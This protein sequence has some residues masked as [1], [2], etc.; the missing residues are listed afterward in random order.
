MIQLVRLG[1]L[2]AIPFVT[3]TTAHTTVNAETIDII[4][5][6]NERTGLIQTLN[7]EDYDSLDEILTAVASVIENNNQEIQSSDDSSSSDDQQQED[8]SSAGG[9]SGSGGS[10]DSSSSSSNSD[11]EGGSN[12]LDT[13]SF[14]SNAPTQWKAQD[15]NVIPVNAE[16]QCNEDEVIKDNSCI[17]IDDLEQSP[18]KQNEVAIAVATAVPGLPDSSEPSDTEEPELEEPEEETDQ[19]EEDKNS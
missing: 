13:Q 7:L 19:Q 6:Y 15:N 1:L 12:E 16:K 18:A 2:V 9:S 8:S 10:G 5:M 4:E 17:P 11:N 3:M 14:N